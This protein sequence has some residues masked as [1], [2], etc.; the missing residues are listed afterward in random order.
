LP[1]RQAEVPGHRRGRALLLLALALF[2]EVTGGPAADRAQAKQLG[3]QAL[4]RPPVARARQQVLGLGQ[5]APLQPFTV[6]AL[7]GAA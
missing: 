2:V 7:G 5:Q 6:G 4:D 1:E 3:G